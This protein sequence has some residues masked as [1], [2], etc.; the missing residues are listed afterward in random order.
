M[1]I[2]DFVKLVVGI[3]SKEVIYHE[4]SHYVIGKVLGHE[5]DEVKV[6]GNG[7]SVK[8]SNPIPDHDMIIIGMSGIIGEQVLSGKPIDMGVDQGF[9][10]MEV[11]RGIEP[12]YQKYIPVVRDMIVKNED[13]IRKFGKK[14]GKDYVVKF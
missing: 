11:V 5:V 8:F 6:Q 4:S 3:P 14:L 9:G 10:D 13:E 1:G 7:G 12:D 2:F